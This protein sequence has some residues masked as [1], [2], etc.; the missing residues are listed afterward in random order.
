[1]AD[2]VLTIGK[3]FTHPVIRDEDILWLLLGHAVGGGK[4][5]FQPKH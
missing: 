4:A 2:M 3:L 1:M 5:G